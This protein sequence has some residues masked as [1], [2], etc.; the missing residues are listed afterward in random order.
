MRK[1]W[2]SCLLTT[3]LFLVGNVA[4]AAE[5]WDMALIG[6]MNIP[7]HVCIEQGAQMALPFV[8]TNSPNITLAR[9]GIPDGHFYSIT[10]SDGANFT[11]GWAA[12]AV[13]GA[14]YL[15]KEGVTGYRNL[16]LS[17]Q[18]DVIAETVNKYI[19]AQRAVFDGEAPLVK[20]SDKKHPR[21]EG[22]FTIQK[23]VQ[24]ILYRTKYFVTVQQNE[25]RIA[26]GI[27][28]ADADAPEMTKALSE[29]LQK[30]KFLK[31]IEWQKL[32][33]S[34]ITE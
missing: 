21:W 1:I 22:S 19:I 10:W 9:M 28:S 2:V 8:E 31:E 23:E 13:I 11:Y 26:I 33:S 34:E 14:Q 25:I 16:S 5:K 20:I 4:T 27:L 12:S 6:R 18:L 15:Q 24:G 17:E 32:S 29:M 30:R 3:F 7:K